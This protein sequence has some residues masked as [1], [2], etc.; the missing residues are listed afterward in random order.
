MT[1]HLSAAA[2]TVLKI[3]D[4]FRCNQHEHHW[5][6]GK[7]HYPI[8]PHGNSPLEKND[9]CFMHQLKSMQLSPQPEIHIGFSHQVCSPVHQ[10]SEKSHLPSFITS[11]PVDTRASAPWT[12]IKDLLAIHSTSW[13]TPHPTDHLWG[14]LTSNQHCR[15][16]PREAISPTKVIPSLGTRSTKT[17]SRGAIEVHKAP[18]L[19]RLRDCCMCG[20]LKQCHHHAERDVNQCRKNYAAKHAVDGFVASSNT[21]FLNCHAENGRFVVSKFVDD[22]NLRKAVRLLQ[23][24][25]G[26]YQNGTALRHFRD[27]SICTLRLM[28]FT[29]WLTV[30]C[31]SHFQSN[32]CWSWEPNQYA[33]QS[34]VWMYSLS[35]FCLDAILSNA[36]FGRKV[37]EILWTYANLK[38][39]SFCFSGLEH[40]LKGLVLPLFHAYL[41]DSF[42]IISTSPSGYNW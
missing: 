34:P 10:E 26:F 30:W 38:Q 37:P 24:D 36:P 1:L 19:S 17:W 5:S 21:S 25:G 16:C 42:E 23:W 33:G 41:Y 11:I 35:D 2:A 15:E 32:S 29:I 8:H 39:C 27:R 14:S 22:V 7:R 40:L 28:H 4:S 3:S 18:H 12:F 6:C 13:I 9:N 31:Q 20:R